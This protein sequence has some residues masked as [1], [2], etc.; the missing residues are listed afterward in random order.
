MNHIC[1]IYLTRVKQKIYGL[2]LFTIIINNF[3]EFSRG[4]AENI[5]PAQIR[6]KIVEHGPKIL[7]DEPNEPSAHA[8]ED[9]NLINNP[10]D[11]ARV[12]VV[13]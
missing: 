6:Y 10:V 4:G 11:G 5:A 9:I 7:L 1:S 13:M 3:N 2:Q 8:E 12:G